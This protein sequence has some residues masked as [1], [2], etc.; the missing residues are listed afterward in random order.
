MWQS[1]SALIPQVIKKAGIGKQISDAMVCAE[2]DKVA[3]HILGDSAEHCRAV[4]LKDRTLW[5]AVLSSAVSNE[6]RLYESDILKA[7]D[8]KCGPG[9]VTGLRFMS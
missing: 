1:I 9:R 7:L 6:L 5:V 2:F 3:A 8:E 4:Y